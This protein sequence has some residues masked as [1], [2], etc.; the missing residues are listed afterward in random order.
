[1]QVVQSAALP[2]VEQVATPSREES[3]ALE[4]PVYSTVGKMLWAI[5]AWYANVADEKAAEA[6]LTAEPEPTLPPL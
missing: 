1:M 6:I 4:D 3:Q 2:A 5:Q